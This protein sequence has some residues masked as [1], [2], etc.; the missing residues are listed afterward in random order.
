MIARNGRAV[1]ADARPVNLALQGGGAHGAFTWG[2]LDRLLEDPRV[3]IEAISGTSAG[4]MNAVVLVDGLMRGGTEG[5]R[6]QLRKF[7]EAVGAA[8]RFNLLQRGPLG[9]LAQNWS[10]DLSLGYYLFDA[11]T[12]SFSPYEFNPLNINPLK[13]ILEG[14]VDFELV[15]SC[16]KLELFIS[17][18]NVETGRVRVFARDK[19]NADMVMASAALP[20]LFQ[21]VEIEGRHYWD[22]GYMGNPVLFPFAYIKRSRD[23]LIV[24]IN[25]IEREGL[26]KTA[27]EILNRINEISFNASLLHELRAIDFVR[28]MLT[29]S[30]LSADHY[31]EMFI[32]IIDGQEALA[33]LGASSKFNPERAFLEHL[34]D[35]GRN[36][37]DEWLNTHYSSLGRES[38]VDIRRLFQGDGYEIDIDAMATQQPPAARRFLSRAAQ[39][40]RKALPRP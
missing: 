37:A 12:R 2:V 17:A 13:D 24:Q 19:L 31:H 23:I 38:T 35:I 11:I 26:P 9:I 5:A 29:S 36:A 22:G 30:Q 27:H 6:D 18:T 39:Y 16:D 7:W 21:A 15:R 25:P 20:T 1:P 32:H 3:V 10:R 40:A 8:S 14:L 4:A 34:F 28:R 33:G